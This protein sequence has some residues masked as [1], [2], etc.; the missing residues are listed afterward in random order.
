M[1]EQA[2]QQKRPEG[3]Q[4][5]QESL[6]SL[7][8]TGSS[9][10]GIEALSTVMKSLGT[11]FPVP[12]V[13]AQHLDPRHPSHLQEILATRSALPVRT[14]T[15]REPLVPGTAYVVP[16]DR[17]VEIS[18]GHLH[19]L[20][21][22]LP[23]PKPSI[24]LLLKT[25]AMAYGEGLV[26]VILTG[27]GSDGA[28]GARQVKEAGGTVI[29][30][31]PETA[32]FSGMPASLAPTTVDMVADLEQIGPLLH[33]LLEGASAA[34]LPETDEPPH[35]D[36]VR[37]QALQAVLAQVREHSGIDFSSY[38][39]PTILRRLHRRMVATGARDLPEYGR[40]LAIHADEYQQLTSSFL[41]KVTEF[42]RDPD[43]FQVL[44]EQ[45][46]PDLIAQAR[47]RGNVLRIWSAGCAT[48]EEAYSLAILVAEALGNELAQFQVQIFA[49]DLD[50]EAIA[51]AR[52]GVYPPA[53][54]E[55]L[56]ED[57]IARYFVGLDGT[58]EVTKQLRG[59]IIF[60]QHDLGQRAPFPR[61]DLVLC[62]NVLIYFTTKLQARA[63]QLFAYALRDGGYLA[64][65]KA[66]TARSLDAYFV[67]V[68]THLKLYRRQG[69][70]VLGPIAQL[71]DLKDLMPR[72]HTSDYYVSRRN[73]PRQMVQPG[74]QAQPS[75]LS[76]ERAQMQGAPGYTPLT[77]SERARTSGEW[78]GALLL[79]L[80]VG[81]VVV[82]R[83]YDIQAI[84]SIALRLLGIYTAA[85][86]EDL[87]HLTQTVPRDALRSVIDAACESE[88]ATYPVGKTEDTAGV[89]GGD[90][91]QAGTPKG[92]EAV[93]TLET[94]LGERL[95]LHVS[96]Y[97][98]PGTRT[99]GQEIRHTADGDAVLILIEDVTGIVL[100]QEKRQSIEERQ[101]ALQ[102]HEQSE[103]ARTL[104]MVRKENER[105]KA[106]ISRIEGINRSL[107]TAN[108]DLSDS[109][110]DLRRSNE[111]LLVGHEEAEANAE[112]VKTLNEEMQATNEE[113]VTIN[114]ELEAT[115]EEL[116]TSNSDLQAR[117][118]E[119]QQASET[120]AAE[121][122]TSE[123]ARAQL[124]AILLSLGDAVLVVDRDGAT[125]L[126][127][128]A[129][130]KMFGG[131]DVT[132]APEDESGHPLPADAT[133]RQRAARRETFTMEFVLTG[134]DGTRR[135]FEATGQPIRD[136]KSKA[137][138]VI[139]TRDITERSIQ[140]FQN[141]FLALASHELATPLTPLKV[142]LHLLSEVLAGRHDNSRAQSYIERSEHQVQRLQRLVQ[143]LLDLGRLQNHRFRVD[144]EPVALNQ[145]VTH[146]VEVAQAMTT[147]QTIRVEQ[148]DT[149]LV[150]EG[151]AIR[152]EQVLL[153][154]LTNAFKHAPRSKYVDVR[155]QRVGREAELQVQDYGGGIAEAALAQIFSRFYQVRRTDTDRPYRR[156][157]GLGLYITQQLV[158]A[159]GGRIEVSS[160]EEP[161]PGH[162]TTFTIYLPLASEETG[163][164]RP[165]K[166]RPQE[167]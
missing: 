51:F 81:V 32:A 31:N 144:P 20:A 26:A 116:H 59:M 12:I 49:T 82:D 109:V 75:P 112:E 46:L 141:E 113:L 43:L 17:H 134:K 72:L 28:E 164:A 10:G 48:G 156:G 64:L 165:H 53:A 87:I 21:D 73:V 54:L 62:R 101:Q 30:E 68:D 35:D 137:A 3:E 22:T 102:Q 163:D 110:L 100:E 125:V 147:T 103:Q 80:P 94:V 106:E 65:G 123:A 161:Q 148:P 145:I 76:P 166:Q 4:P 67:P 45:V 92:A 93:V 79:G 132:I 127:N 34:G 159:H 1:A 89:N 85:Q 63:L 29:V 95:R 33:D 118:R 154:L 52:R 126:T 24:N 105:L 38:K 107:L 5:G 86:G 120:L 140:R 7:V 69:E 6:Y 2:D 158:A 139:A 25:A 119:L 96:C 70:R 78:L 16:A 91:Q 111:E 160:V 90:I 128:A 129:Y 155:L 14:V 23:R 152:L 47:K 57:L 15:D 151:D 44:R 157:L 121:R 167:Q 146:S 108:Q 56:S 124:E 11:D 9:A 150:I 117:S 74:T 99:T 61:I 13:I 98:S 83:R 19:L 60:G 50:D 153:N 8:V 41:I 77:N 130:E 66:E 40:Y 27:T 114:E 84:N 143:D 135:W 71:S 58:Y 36:N 97:C 133:P 138:G 162:G 55:G 18:D 88:Q 39:H 136:A 131:A 42:F 115:V 122:A 142:Y 149:P 37:E 104:G